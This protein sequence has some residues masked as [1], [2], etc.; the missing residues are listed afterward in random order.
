LAT[1]L[2]LC[3]RPVDV[4]E[5]GEWRARA[6]REH[7][8][9]PAVGAR[10]GG[11][12]VG[13]EVEDQ[14]H[15]VPRELRDERVEVRFR[16][17]LLVEAAVI[18]DVVAVRA[19]RARGKGGGRIAIADSQPRKIGDQETTLTKIETALKLQSIRASR[20]ARTQCAT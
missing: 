16:A 15:V 9:P 1:E 20:Q 8:P 13:H 12:V 19:R 14:T 7:V 4:E 10:I 6:V 11:H 5:A 18:A 3:G 17:E 2:R